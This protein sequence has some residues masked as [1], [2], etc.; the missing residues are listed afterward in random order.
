VSEL[1]ILSGSDLA[2]LMSF[3]DYV[4]AVEDAFRRHAEEGGATPLPLHIPAGGGSFHV[5]AA[6]LTRGSGYVAVK[7]N[8][9]FPDNKRCRGLPTIQG[10]VLLSDGTSGTPLALLDSIEITAQRTGAATAIAARHLAPEDA[11]VATIC[12]CGA[13]GRIQ[14]I[15]LRH[16]RDIRRVFAWDCDASSAADYARRMSEE[17]GIAVVPAVTLREATRASQVI[18]TCTSAAAPFLDVDDVAPG[19]F[20][21]AIGADN[22]E[23][24]EIGPALMGRAKIVADLRAQ[25]AV[26]GDLHH[27]IHAGTMSEGDI[28]AE[29]GELIAGRKRG[30]ERDDEIIIFDGTGTGI[31][32]VAAAACAYEKARERG[33]GLRCTLA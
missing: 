5:K 32:D 23:K 14:L 10:A 20:I 16:V 4:E 11:R 21:A 31:Q 13:Q 1:L 24:S 17:C 33:A 12:G 28:H 30:R 7:I 25:C 3:A 22:P 18:V 19:T 26:M 15:A 9:N 27:A 29:L 8:A 6:R 2:S